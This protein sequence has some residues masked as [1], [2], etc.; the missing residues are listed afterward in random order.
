MTRSRKILWAIAALVVAVVTIS[1]F[2]GL[3]SATDLVSG[4]ESAR[5]EAATLNSQGAQADA[6]LARQA[7]FADEL[8]RARAAVPPTP[9]L[10]GLISDLEAQAVRSGLL[11]LSG[12]PSRTVSDSGETW[13]ISMTV[14]GAPSA[15]AQFT[16]DLRAAP[17]LFIVDSL[18]LQS[19][20]D[21]SVTA[22]MTVEFFTTVGELESFPE[23]Q[24]EA[25]ES[26]QQATLEDEEE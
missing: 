26:G 22:N 13:Q 18:S 14:A 2:G 20:A 1:S 16:G 8:A 24:R 17:R 3:P 9:E 7:E 12:S 11:W 4:A 25:I 21:G 23:D 6:A 10:S 15:V 5:S 19:D